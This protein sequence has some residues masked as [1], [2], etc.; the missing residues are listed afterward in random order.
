[1]AAGSAIPAEPLAL[2]RLAVAVCG[3]H[4][5]VSVEDPGRVV[6][7]IDIEAVIGGPLRSVSLAEDRV[8]GGC[9]FAAMLFG[10][11]RVGIQH[12]D[13]L[14]PTSNTTARSAWTWLGSFLFPPATAPK[15]HAGL[16]ATTLPDGSKTDAVTSRVQ[17]VTQLWLKDS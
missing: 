14:A 11:V 8:P 7:P 12:A 1:M 13:R 6:D 3:H 16:D 4:E 5:L 2:V 9:R 17:R 15:P 10:Q